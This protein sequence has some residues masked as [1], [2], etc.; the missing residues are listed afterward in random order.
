VQ[1]VFGVIGLV[2]AIAGGWYAW[3]Q[4][5]SIWLVAYVAFL[6]MWVIARGFADI[7]TD[8]Q[9]VKRAIFFL[10]GPAL[11]VGTTYLTYQ[12]WGLMWLSTLL[13]FFIALPIGMAITRAMFPRI[14]L[15]EDRDTEARKHST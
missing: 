5:H 3:T 6:T 15:E 14:A 13:G 8:P 2:A 7:V 4:S 11:S 12:L 10:L 9:K 1:G